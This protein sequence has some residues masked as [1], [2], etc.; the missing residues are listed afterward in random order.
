MVNRFSISLIEKCFNIPCLQ[1]PIRHSW[2]LNEVTIG[3]PM[4]SQRKC[5]ALAQ[6]SVLPHAAQC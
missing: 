2:S 4:L 1:Q 6:L 3:C 5:L